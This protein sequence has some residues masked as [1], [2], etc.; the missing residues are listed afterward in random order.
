[1]AVGPKAVNA[2]SKDFWSAVFAKANLLNA[3]FK[4]GKL[5]NEKKGR[6]PTN[7]MGRLIRFEPDPAIFKRDLLDCPSRRSLKLPR[8]RAPSQADA[9]CRF[10]AI[11]RS[12]DFPKV[13]LDTSRLA[14]QEHEDC[15]WVNP[16]GMH[17]S[18]ISASDLLLVNHDGDVIE[19][20][21]R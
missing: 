5:K 8:R 3:S 14:I 4:Q 17:F 9:C 11:C 15:F 18:L 2:L 7:Q 21:G 12:T 10:P 16:F 13:S 1:M 19:A 20:T 6:S